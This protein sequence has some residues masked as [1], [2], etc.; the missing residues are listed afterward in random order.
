MASGDA[1]APLCSGFENEWHVPGPETHRVPQEVITAAVRTVTE[2]AAAALGLRHVHEVKVLL[3][4]AKLSCAGIFLQY[5]F[6]VTGEAELITARVAR[7]V[8]TVGKG[9]DEEASAR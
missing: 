6:V 4:V 8:G 3:A 7:G 5:S 2:R 9:V 1:V